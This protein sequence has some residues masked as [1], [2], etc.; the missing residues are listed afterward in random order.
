VKNSLGGTLIGPNSNDW[1]KF[2]NLSIGLDMVETEVCQW[3]CMHY[4][5]GGR[6]FGPY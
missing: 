1:N 3:G 4:A 5:L 2:F 6:R